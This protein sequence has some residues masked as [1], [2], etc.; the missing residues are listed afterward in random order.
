MS[1]KIA[2]KSIWPKITYNNLSSILLSQNVF[3]IL[4]K[5]FNTSWVYQYRMEWWGNPIRPHFI[6]IVK[7]FE[8]YSNFVTNHSVISPN[9]HLPP[10][11]QCVTPLLES[12]W[13]TLTIFSHRL[14][15][16]IWNMKAQC[17]ERIK[18]TFLLSVSQNNWMWSIAK[19]SIGQDQTLIELI[20]FLSLSWTLKIRFNHQLHHPKPPGNSTQQYLSCN[21]PDIDKTLIVSSWKHLKQF[22][23]VTKIFVQATFVLVTFV[24][25]GN[26]ST[27]ADL[28]LTKL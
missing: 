7:L 10:Q 14:W 24:H 9:G 21:W 16:F 3:Q 2:Y 6:H 25:N 20:S 27:V 15:E 19:L 18:D 12:L 28:I 17:K 13:T 5:E 22:P 8:T 26:F 23:I 11:N 4:H 1:H